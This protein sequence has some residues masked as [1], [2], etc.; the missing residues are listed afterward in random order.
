MLA[1]PNVALAQNECGVLPAAG[2][3]VSCPASGSPYAA[4]IT[5]LPTADLTVVL[6]AN[7]S[8]QTATPATPGVQI[9]GTGDLAVDG[10]GASGATSGALS[11]GV[12]VS[13][14]GGSADAGLASAACSI[15]GGAIKAIT[16]LTVHRSYAEKNRYDRQATESMRCTRC[17]RGFDL[18]AQPAARERLVD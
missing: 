11:N 10:S 18:P 1:V 7:L 3:L 9:L 5:Y 4:G 8:I 12:T 2:G 13:S 15:G 17:S 6:P 16:P 14:L